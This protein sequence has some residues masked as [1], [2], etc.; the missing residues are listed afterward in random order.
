M[1]RSSLRNGSS[2]VS[3]QGVANS[4]A[5][6]PCRHLYSTECPSLRRIRSLSLASAPLPAVSARSRN[7][8]P[9]CPRGRGLRWSS[10]STSIRST[11][12]ASSSCLQPHTSMHGRRRRAWRAKVEPDHVYVIQPNTS[13][14]I[15][16]GVLSVTP[17]PDDRRPALS[18]RS[19][20]SLAGAVQG[21]SR[22]RRD[23]L[24][25][26]LRRH[27]RAWRNQGGWRRDVRAGRASA[28]HA[29]MP[30]SAIASGAV[31]LV[32]PPDEIADRLAALQ[33][34]PVPAQPPDA[35]RTRDRRGR[36]RVPA[37]H[38]RAA[39]TAPA[40]ISASIATRRSSGAP[41][42]ACCCAASRRRRLRRSFSSAT[43]TRPRRSTATC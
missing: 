29:G 7:C 27:A 31:D 30:Q 19:F 17:R 11:R 22:G 8:W 20:P 21:S 18:G 25:H 23:P 12:A 5:A 2:V 39:R 9:R 33:E 16:D 3:T 41:R 14:A 42:G 10:S 35:V 15:A 38:R 32:L 6:R 28:Q 24:R 34:H 36:R 43:A 4:P 1:P 26:R 40:S 37:R 13:V